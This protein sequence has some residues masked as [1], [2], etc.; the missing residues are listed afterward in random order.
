MKRDPFAI[1]AAFLLAAMLVGGFRLA[2]LQIFGLDRAALGSVYAGFHDRSTPEYPKFL[3]DVM[4]RT[5][6][7]D[8]IAI[9][10]PMRKWDA[11]YAYAYYRASYL[12]AGREVLPLVWR[13]DELLEP[14]YERAEYVAS[15]QMNLRR[16][17]L[18][19]VFRSHGGIL[20]RKVGR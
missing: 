9:F 11:G 10:V 16:P 13:S 4:P 5:K 7:G 12:L 2:F 3:A 15:W 18:Q 17:D 14:N 6:A 8:R 1:V 20:Y 19:E